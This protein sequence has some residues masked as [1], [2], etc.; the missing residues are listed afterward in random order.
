MHPSEPDEDDEEHSSTR[1]DLW[2]YTRVQW[3][4]LRVSIARFGRSQTLPTS[5]QENIFTRESSPEPI[6]PVRERLRN[7]VFIF[8]EIPSR[9]REY[10]ER[11]HEPGDAPTV[12]GDAAMSVKTGP[13]AVKHTHSTQRSQSDLIAR[14]TQDAIDSKQLEEFVECLRELKEKQTGVHQNGARVKH[15]Q[16]SPCGKW[17]VV[18][19]QFSCIV[20]RVGVSCMLRVTYAG[21]EADRKICAGANRVLSTAPAYT[22][23]CEAGGVGAG[24]KALVDSVE[25]LGSVLGTERESGKYLWAISPAASDDFLKE[26]KVVDTM[27]LVR[28]L[29]WI[30]WLNN[31]GISRFLRIDIPEP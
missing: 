17:L 13:S 25:G 1:R 30:V 6:Y 9:I 19:Y 4:R 20:Y 16:F 7:L 23:V 22:T 8:R 5:S 12:V 31:D 28:K 27:P 29:K 15:M 21:I 26:F 10:A 24:W 11:R 3:F 14:T 2:D 18:C